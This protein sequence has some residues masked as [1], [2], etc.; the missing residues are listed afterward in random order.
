[1]LKAEG[2][3]ACS[4]GN[5]CAMRYL[6]PEP[7]LRMGL[8]VARNRVASAGMDL[9]DGLADGVHQIAEASG[10][11][12]I[13]DADA[14]PIEPA[15]REWFSRHGDDA[16]TAALTGGDDYELLIAVKPKRGRRLAAA[17]R[18]GDVPLTLVGVCTEDRA[19]VLKSGRPLPAG[20]HHFR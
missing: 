17:R 3:A 19:V 8:L 13:V 14:L 5:S 18:H 2:L 12:A 9:S 16:T 10:L 11:G 1:M 7:R 6:F 4:D 20:Y 15:A